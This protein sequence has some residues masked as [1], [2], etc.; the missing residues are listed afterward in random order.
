MPYAVPQRANAWR[1]PSNQPPIRSYTKLDTCQQ[2][3][4]LLQALPATQQLGGTNHTMS[5][6]NVSTCAHGKERCAPR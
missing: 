3:A 5:Q 6:H 2:E 1:R 4:L